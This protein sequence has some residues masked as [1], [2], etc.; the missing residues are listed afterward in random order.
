M[1]MMIWEWINNVTA[2]SIIHDK[3]DKISRSSFSSD[4][5]HWG[6]YNVGSGCNLF[7][8]HHHHCFLSG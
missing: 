4:S 2:D 5:A 1:G 8:H 6:A 3:E 7:H